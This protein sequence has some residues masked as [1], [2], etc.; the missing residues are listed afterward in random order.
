MNYNS[1]TGAREGDEYHF[2]EYGP[3]LTNWKK[4]WGWDYEKVITFE[5]VQENYKN[6]LIYDY[7]NHDITKGPLKSYDL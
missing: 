1:A 3:H 7:F 5:Y 2:G 4:R 6:T